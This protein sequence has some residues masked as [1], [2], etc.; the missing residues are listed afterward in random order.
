MKNPK[1]S[2]S[3][4]K[5]GVI[6]F[7]FLF[8]M[9]LAAWKGLHRLPSVAP[10]V[11]PYLSTMSTELVEQCILENGKSPT[12]SWEDLL[13]IRSSL[14]E[15]DAR[16]LIEQL[17]NHVPFS[18][19]NWVSLPPSL[20]KTV[21][22]HREIL[23]H[24]T[25]YHPNTYRFPVSGTTWFENS[26]GADREGGLRKHEGTDL[27]GKEG[28]P[29]VSI[30]G[31]KIEQLG[32]N[33]LGGERVGVRGD[34]GNYYYYAHLQFISPSLVKGNRI[35]AGDFVGSMGN[36]GD[37]ITTPDHLHFGIELPNGQWINPY[38]FL[39]VWQYWSN[40]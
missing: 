29:I 16:P 21:R 15:R 27:F 6:Q 7:S 5:R 3:R 17:R 31:G 11:Y 24:Y 26:F 33:R 30:C 39:K 22:R 37:A 4:F 2:L 23:N 25:F 40:L 12:I 14:S 10:D 35:E 28:T 18:D 19:L 1:K 34:D 13:A 38:P 9:A 36:T 8:L 20:L 32:W